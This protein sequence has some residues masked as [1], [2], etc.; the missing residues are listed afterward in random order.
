MKMTKQDKEL[1]REQY[2]KVWHRRDGSVDEKMVDY[3]TK[4]T[5]GYVMIDGR[6]ITFDKPSIKT[7]FWFGEHT[8]DYDEV[9]KHAEACS[10]SEKYFVAENLHDIDWRLE[11]IEDPYCKMYI[12]GRG[13]SNQSNDCI[14]GSIEFCRYGID[15]PRIKDAREMTNEERE[16]YADFIKD[17]RDK[18][19]KRLHTY[20]K[21]YGLSKCHFG[22]Y[23]ADR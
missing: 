16:Q 5:S 1:V 20:L 4:K 15:M 8:Y 11:A 19:E 3:C 7:D 10:K 22:T 23:W 12:G 9:T 17:E 14:L 18:F 6:M 21:R 13:Y 2:A